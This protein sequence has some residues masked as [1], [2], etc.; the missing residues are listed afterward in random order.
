M[1]DIIRDK[2]EA[3]FGGGKMQC[4]ETVLRIA[5]EAVGKDPAPVLHA[6]SGFCAGMARTKGQ[7]GAL[8]GA[9]MALGV[10]ASTTDDPDEIGQDREVV[11]DLT[12]ELLQWFRDEFGS[13]NCFELTGC[14]FL[15]LEGKERFN[16]GNVKKTCV[17]MCVETVHA[18]LGLLRDAGRI[19]SSEN[20]IAARLAPCGLSCGHCAAYAGGVAQTSAASL[21]AALGENFGSYAERFAASNPAFGNYAG[22]RE[23]LDYLA[24]GSCGGCREAGCLFQSCKVSDCVD[25]HEVDY[26]YE[27]AEFPC[28]RHGMP[29]P[30]A[31]RWRAN[32]EKMAEVGVEAWYDGC[33]KRPRYP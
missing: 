10:L 24:S 5:M 21:A 27:C 11:F 18:V 1:T 31:E 23:L 22:F 2:A 3:W 4:A 29:G 30:L 32:N 6:A 12:Q 15:T 33:C 19:P 13:Y 7:C 14:D 16:Q 28:D 26:C 8:S 25:E 9:L 20:M 17:G